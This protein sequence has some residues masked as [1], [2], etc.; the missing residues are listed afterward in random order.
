MAVAAGSGLLWLGASIA[1]DRDSYTEAVA[2]LVVTAQLVSVGL[3]AMMGTALT[4]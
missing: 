2:T 1:G 4:A 3:V